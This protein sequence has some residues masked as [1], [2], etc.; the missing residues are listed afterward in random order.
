M[1]VNNILKIIK[2]IINNIYNDDKL[3]RNNMN[4]SNDKIYINDSYD[5][6]DIVKFVK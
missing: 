5:M 6:F 4:D 3:Y 1:F 2:C